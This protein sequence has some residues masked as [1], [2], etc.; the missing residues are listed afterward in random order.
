MCSSLCTSSFSPNP[1]L[2]ARLSDA[3]MSVNLSLI[4][5]PL[6]G[7]SSFY[8]FRASEHML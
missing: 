6:L 1:D 3:T 4:L 5:L 2:L 7:L 8:S